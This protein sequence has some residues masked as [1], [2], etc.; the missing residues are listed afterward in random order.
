MHV[1]LSIMGF[2]N[3]LYFSLHFVRIFIFVFSSITSNI[4]FLAF[5]CSFIFLPFYQ[6]V[7]NLLLFP[8]FFVFACT[9]KRTRKC[10]IYYD[11]ANVCVW[12]RVCSRNSN[13]DSVLLIQ[14][15]DQSKNPVTK[16]PKNNLTLSSG[17]YYV[18]SKLKET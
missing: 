10:W 13:Y 9:S 17:I 7:L 3:I 14:R 12:E 5:A 1:F 16:M 2:F 8:L 18:L 6:A 15:L 11:L 4:R